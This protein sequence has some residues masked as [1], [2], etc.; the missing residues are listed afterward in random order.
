[1]INKL[2]SFELKH[3]F[4][5]LNSRNYAF[6]FIA[7]FISLLIIYGNSFNCEWLFDDYTNIL[8]NKNIHIQTLSWPDL[9]KVL[10]KTPTQGLPRTVAYL[11]FALNYYAGGLDVF[12]YHL[13]NFFIH[14]I[15]AVFLFL[16]IYK[17]LSLPLLSEKFGH[18]AYPIALLSAFLWATNPVQV[19]AVTYIV[20]RMTSLTGMFYIMSMYF[21]LCGRTS[22]VTWRR[23]LS[24]ALSIL[25]AL[26]AFGTKENAA[27]LPISVLAFDLLL[28]QGISK[29]YFRNYLF[30]FLISCLIISGLGILYL[31]LSDM[32]FLNYKPWTFTLPERLLTE[33]RVMFFYISLLLYPTGSRLTMDHDIQLSRS[34]T[35][36]WTTAFAIIIVVIIIGYALYQSRKRPLLSFCILFFFLNHIIEGSFIALDIIFEHRNYIPSMF[37]FVPIAIFMINILDYFAYR[38]SLQFIMALGMVFIIA[39]QAHTVYLRNDIMLYQKIL[40]DDN[41]KKQPNLSR[42][43][44]ALSKMYFDEG[45]FDKGAMENR[46]ALALNRYPN[47]YQPALNHC[48]LG[49]YYL[50][51]K[52][53]E[54]KASFHYQQAL[55]LQP[56]M[57]TAY[58]GLAMVM[59]KKGFPAQ[60]HDFIQKAIQFKPNDPDL[61]HNFAQILLKEGRYDEAIR[62]SRKAIRLQNDSYNEP[63]AVMAEAFRRKGNFNRAIFY[64][65][66]YLLNNP[67]HFEGRL[68][69]VELYSLQNKKDL[70]IQTIGIILAL[71]GK[72]GIAQAIKETEQKKDIIYRPERKVIY[73]ILKEELKGIL[74]DFT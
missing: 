31:K 36:P 67:T 8:L 74:P 61:H 11:S 16:F 41:I 70:L 26:L 12:G 17:T 69:L 10:E 46:I 40:W 3:N 19:N 6:A 28:I 14:Y 68:A 7:I 73:R 30:V 4:I 9:S 25:C 39:A 34:L 38:K 42:P 72:E 51:I 5:F 24:F 56:N 22:V 63:L 49:S 44:S 71:K 55:Q 45:N 35:D 53:N 57:P 33:P 50:W 59:L 23:I 62:Q 27:M 32:I 13:V 58:S 47:N 66:K 20:Q 18:I 54:D 29:K 64:W 48:A 1:L 15:T 2:N 65:E 52:K 43:H 60:A 37:F 21:Y